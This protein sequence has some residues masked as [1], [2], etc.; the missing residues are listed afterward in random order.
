MEQAIRETE[1]HQDMKYRHWLALLGVLL[2]AGSPSAPLLAADWL[3]VAGLF[4]GAGVLCLSGAAIITPD[5][6]PSRMRRPW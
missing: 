5:G 2:I 6:Q 1:S 3:P 4:I